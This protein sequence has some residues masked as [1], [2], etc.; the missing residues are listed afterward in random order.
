MLSPHTRRRPRNISGKG[1]LE[2]ARRQT[3][4]LAGYLEIASEIN[5]PP[6]PITVTKISNE[7]KLR[8]LALR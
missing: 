1:R 4:L 2:A 3:A 8:P 5:D 7:V 6:K